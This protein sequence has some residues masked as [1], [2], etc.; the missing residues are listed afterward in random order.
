MQRATRVNCCLIRYAEVGIKSD[1]TRA[2]WLKRLRRNAETCLHWNDVPFSRIVITQGRLIA[3]TDDQRAPDLLSRVFGVSSASPA[4]EL[5]LD[6]D[7]MKDEAKRLFR[8]HGP[9]SFRITTQRVTKKYP[10][11]SQ[12]INAAIGEAVY[13]IGGTVDLK[14]CELDIRFEIIHDSSYV[15]T[16]VVRGV[17]GLP[18]GVQRT[19]CAVIRTMRDIVAAWL[20]MRRGG[21]LE[22]IVLD[23]PRA[24]GYID[25][26]MDASCSGLRVQLVPDDASMRLAL[27]SQAQRGQEVVVS[28]D[29]LGNDAGLVEL[30]PCE[31]YSDAMIERT[32]EHA[33]LR[34]PPALEHHLISAGG[35]VYHGED[36]L[37]IRRKDEGTWI[38]PKGGVDPNEFFREAALR[39]IREETGLADVEAG[40]FIGKTRYSFARLGTTYTKDVYYYA[41]Q[42]GDTN[43]KLEH[44]FDDYVF[45]P[46]EAAL[47]LASFEND[48]RI[49]RQ[50][51]RILRA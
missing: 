23:G 24:T 17:G 40:R 7:V 30:C 32:M 50:A 39:E 3:Y 14:N 9:S 19:A 31:T 46:Y 5:P 35:I 47:E 25:I 13:D 12:Q 21:M 48:R 10:L 2:A 18:L 33:G 11:T 15:F 16:N 6:L 51:A 36:I 34:E 38:P 22:L 49:M 1:Q 37:L 20:F 41:C 26:L 27:E 42:T 4:R 28:A 8:Q 44:L 45:L 43:V 29:P